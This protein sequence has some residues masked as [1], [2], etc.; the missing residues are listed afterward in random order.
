MRKQHGRVSSALFE[1]VEIV[2]TK[3][4]S[5]SFPDGRTHRSDSVAREPFHLSRIF[6]DKVEIGQ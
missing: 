6:A 2:K 4:A 5:G 3:F 1:S